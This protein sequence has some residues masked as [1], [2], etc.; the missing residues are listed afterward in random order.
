MLKTIEVHTTFPHPSPNA[1]EVGEEC[2]SVPSHICTTSHQV[3]MVDKRGSI[4]KFFLLKP[5]PSLVSFVVY[6][7]FRHSHSSMSNR[8]NCSSLSSTATNTVLSELAKKNIEYVRQQNALLSLRKILQTHM[9][10]KKVPGSDVSY[11]I[12]IFTQTNVS[13]FIHAA[14]R[15][16]TNTR[17]VMVKPRNFDDRPQIRLIFCSSSFYALQEE[18]ENITASL[19]LT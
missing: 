8:K 17:Q 15:K 7:T 19:H 11:D 16:L 1:L 9:S 5:P 3:F 2:H 10:F 14:S 4:S 12:I 13:N 18:E 6:R